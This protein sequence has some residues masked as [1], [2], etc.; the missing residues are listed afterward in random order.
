MAANK[1][2]TPNATCAAPE[3]HFNHVV[4]EV[5]STCSGAEVHPLPLLSS[6]NASGTG[7]HWAAGRTS[8]LGVYFKDAKLINSLVV[9]DHEF[10]LDF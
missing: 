5:A 4:P 3:I 2:Q 6:L 7:S 9:H 10:G 8:F 1:Q